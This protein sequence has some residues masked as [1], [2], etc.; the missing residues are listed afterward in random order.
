[1]SVNAR[2]VA[3]LAGE[4]IPRERIYP[5]VCLDAV[6]LYYTFNFD[7]LPDDFGNNRP[8]VERLLIQVHLF[9][10]HDYNP[11]ALRVLTKQR[12]FRAGFGWP[13]ETDAT[14]R[15]AKS[16]E[17]GQHY[18]FEVEAAGGVDFG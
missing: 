2:I 17:E 6:D 1:M 5:G 8:G 11:L 13:A 4:E 3:A 18:V 15:L 14:N 10:P 9:C 16:G 12:L 7:A